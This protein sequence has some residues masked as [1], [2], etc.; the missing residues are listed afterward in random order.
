MPLNRVS[1]A[2]RVVTVAMGLLMFAWAAPNASAGALRYAGKMAAKGTAVA[3]A[4]T[5]TG[6]QAALDK[7]QSETGQA[8]SSA[9]NS[10]RRSLANVGRATTNG[11]KNGGAAVYYSAKRAPHTV[12]HG[13]RMLWHKIW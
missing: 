4:A 9:G 3:A 1:G 11:A 5:A 8:T 12:A 13:A 7:V 6:G 10:L 2:V